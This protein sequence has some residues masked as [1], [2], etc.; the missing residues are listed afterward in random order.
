MKWSEQAWQQ[1]TPIYQSI[2]SMPFIT[3]LTNGTLDKA[4]FRFYMMQDSGYLDH[5]GRALAL[6][7]ARATHIGDALTFMR[8]AENAILVENSLHESY[9]VDFGVADK[10]TLQPACHHYIHF[11]KSTAA[12]EAVEVAMGAVLPCFWIYKAVGDFILQQ[13]Q[14]ADNPYQRWIDTYGGE[15]FGIAVQQAIAICDRMAAQTTDAV[16]EAMTGAFITASR[17]EYDFW[18]AAYTLRTW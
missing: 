14:I 17:L 9:F 1:I 3:E 4:K 18:D 10:G 11:L 12:L 13:P 15:E 16:R 8:F 2:L 5:F 7:G 6:I